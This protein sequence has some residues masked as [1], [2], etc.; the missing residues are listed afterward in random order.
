MTGIFDRPAMVTVADRLLS[1]F[2]EVPRAVVIRCVETAFDDVPDGEGD[3]H[4]AETV[5]RLARLRLAA[6]RDS[7]AAPRRAAGQT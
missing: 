6:F 1:D 4:C 2:R 7:A 3:A 5:D